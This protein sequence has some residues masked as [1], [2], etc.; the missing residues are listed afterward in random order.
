MDATPYLVEIA[1]ALE[2]STLE[3]ILIGNAGAA[4]HGAPVTTVDF[5]FLYRASKTNEAKVR[6][7]AEVLGG[8]LIQ[9]FPTLSTVYRIQR[10]S[11]ELQV[12]MTSQIHGASSFNSLRSRSKRILIEGR[13]IMVASLA[14]I[15]KSKKEANRP[16]DLAVLHVLEKTLEESGEEAHDAGGE[17]RSNAR[18]K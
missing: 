5:D 10:V 9:T 6:R 1:D 17:A 11:P 12:D 16:R 8:A 3:A 14:D 15:I 18:G 7:L 4:L 2:K 13:T